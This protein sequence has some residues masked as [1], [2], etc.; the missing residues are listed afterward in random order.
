MES[1]DKWL[2]EEVIPEG[3]MSRSETNRVQ[4]ERTT[5]VPTVETPLMKL[6]LIDVRGV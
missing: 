6:R 1:P 5:G 3:P 2:I 4:L